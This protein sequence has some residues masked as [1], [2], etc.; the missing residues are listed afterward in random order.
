MKAL[1]TDDMNY[2][3]KQVRIIKLLLDKPYLQKDLAQRLGISGA[4]LLYHLKK[5]ENE[6]LITK[7]TKIQVGNVKIKEISININGLQRARKI[8]GIEKKEWTLISGFGKDSQLGKPFKL[9]SIAKQLLTDHGYKISKIVA[10]I[11]PESN[12]NAAK[13]LETIDRVIT[14]NYV[15]YRNGDSELMN[16]L[17]FFL[18]EEQKIAD[19]IIDLTPLTKL[20]TLKLLELSYK[21]KIPSFYLGKKKN[22]DDYLM[23]I[24]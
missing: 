14:Y 17:E 22:D 24:I 1:F 7:N 21:F 5:L 6:E 16:K 11:T 12:I 20:L 19:L 8:A 4:G 2:S 3:E 10:F 23:W 9:P 18:Q 13:E 15:D